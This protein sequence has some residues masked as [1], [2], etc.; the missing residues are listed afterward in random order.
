[1]SK[2]RMSR[3]KKKGTSRST[4]RVR[5]AR[6]RLAKVANKAMRNREFFE[7]LLDDP[8]AALR[9][10]GWY[11]V[12]KDMKTL[13]RALRGRLVSVPF[14]AVDFIEKQLDHPGWK[15]WAEPTWKG[16]PPPPPPFHR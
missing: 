12:Q 13:T 3:K 8:A 4:R 14:N 16:W 7:A 1:M 2:N 10:A 5:L 15:G 9:D 11:L 6:A